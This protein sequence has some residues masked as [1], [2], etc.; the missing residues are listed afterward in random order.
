MSTQ[1]IKQ[2]KY[3]SNHPFELAFCGYRNTGKTTLIASLTELLAQDFKLGYLKHDAHHFEMDHPGKDT[4]ILRRSGATQV[5]IN[6]ATKKASL[7]FEPLDFLE[8]Q[9]SFESCDLL[10]IEGYKYQ[11]TVKIIVLDEAFEILKPIQAGEIENVLAFVGQMPPES[12][13]ENLKAPY[14]QRDDLPGLYSLVTA[15]FQ[16]L[17]QQIPLFGLV[18]GGG[19]STRM[20]QDKALLHYQGR[21]QLEVSYDLLLPYCEQVFISTRQEQGLDAE[22]QAGLSIGPEAYLYDRFLDFGPIGGIL[23][24]M[25]A[26]PEAAWLVVACDLPLLDKITLDYLLHHRNP[27]KL[28]SAFASAHD[29]LP[30]PLCAIYEPRMRSRLLAF[31]GA[32]YSCPRKVL[33]NSEIKTLNLPR[34]RALDNANTPED[35]LN[36]KAVLKE[37]NHV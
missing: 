15:Y 22:R 26:H 8:R 20:Q 17:S 7:G 24:A 4:D 14:F 3:S 21:P 27:Y 13:P 31:L 2:K 11:P 12:A 28:A 30:E 36:M 16:G 10:L 23:S 25:T 35:Y 33:L 32:G 6:S 5:M 37:S 9:R 29:G 18:L 34:T 1:T 19:R